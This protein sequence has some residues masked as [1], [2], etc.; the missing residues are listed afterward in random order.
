MWIRW[1]SPPIPPIPSPVS[2]HIS[3]SKSQPG[4]CLKMCL[5][6]V[7]PVSQRSFGAPATRHEFSPPITFLRCLLAQSPP[8]PLLRAMF[9]A[10]IH[11]SPNRTVYKWPNVQESAMARACPPM[12][13]HASLKK[14][15]SC[16]HASNEI[17][18]AIFYEG[19]YVVMIACSRHFI[20]SHTRKHL[21][22]ASFI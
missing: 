4:F 13:C 17:E 3:I 21:S 7:W 14:L 8:P 10:F 5:C 12:W 22:F 18:T 15:S 2:N 19:L 11:P 1:T 20:Y 9:H 16:I 6:D